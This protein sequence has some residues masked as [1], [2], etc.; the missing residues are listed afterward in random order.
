M[1]EKET[2]FS[3]KV[4]YGGIFSFKEFYK[5]CHAW[6]LEEMGM[7]ISETKYEEKIAGDITQWWEGK[8]SN[9]YLTQ[10][11]LLQ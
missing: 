4:Q 5:F 9:N 1:A 10:I 11:K 7:D 8:Y 2:I 6:I 3:S